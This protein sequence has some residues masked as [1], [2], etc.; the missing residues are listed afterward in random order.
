MKNKA[1]KKQPGKEDD[2]S[3]DRLSNLPEAVIYHILSFLDT[4]S[5]VQTSLLSRQWKCTWKHLPVLDL[6][7]SSEGFKRYVEKV[8]SLRYDLSL[9]KVIF[10]DRLEESDGELEN[11]LLARVIRYALSHETQHLAIRLPYRAGPSRYPSTD[12]LGLDSDNCSLRTLELTTFCFSNGF[13][14]SSFLMLEK[15]DLVCCTF[16]AGEEDGVIDLFSNL[17][18]LK[19]LVLHAFFN[20]GDRDTRFRISGLQLL[21]LHLSYCYFHKMEVYA[22][23]LKNFTLT[24][25]DH[26]VEFT[27]LTLPSLDHAHI[28]VAYEDDTEKHLIMLLQGLN[29]ATSLVLCSRTIRMLKDISGD[30]EDQ[31]SPFTRLKS[32]IMRSGNDDVPFAVLDYLLKGS[33]DAKPVVKFR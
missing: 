4:R 13:R 11:S 23:N 5:A 33:S 17:P 25:A 2:S 14:R 6:R 32:L 12:L 20:Y 29:N 15:L 26:I 9:R 10:S 27:E 7:Y 22:P 16:S 19:H 3:L 24:Y 18:C 1:P 31:P 21:S 30:L 8:L 28:R